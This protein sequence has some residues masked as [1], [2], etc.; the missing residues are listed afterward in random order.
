MDRNGM[1]NWRRYLL[2]SLGICI[3]GVGLL[4]FTQ[5]HI[6]RSNA[7]SFDCRSRDDPT[8]SAILR[9]VRHLGGTKDLIL[10]SGNVAETF[11]IDSS[12]SGT[13]SASRT[14]ASP[15]SSIYFNRQT[16]KVVETTLGSN[17]ARRILVDRCNE[18]IS[19]SMCTKHIHR[20]MKRNLVDLDD[21]VAPA[22]S[23]CEVWKTQRDL[24]FE[25]EFAC[26]PHE[27]NAKTH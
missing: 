8:K 13:Y 3:A 7:T 9:I 20:I 18:K 11:Q 15:R 4:W 6:G 14:D 26:T 5:S 22:E 10:K 12:Q 1:T 2:F 16:G 17:L 21:C 23:E 24:T 27:D 25:L 19:A